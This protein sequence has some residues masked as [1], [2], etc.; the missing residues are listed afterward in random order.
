MNSSEL[1]IREFR[2]RYKAAFRQRNEEWIIRFFGL[3]SGTCHLLPLTAHALT[4]LGTFVLAPLSKPALPAHHNQSSTADKEER[5][6]R[7][8]RS[9]PHEPYREPQ[10]LHYVDRHEFQRRRQE[11]HSAH[12]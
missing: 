12:Y 7:K 1:S 2:P 4:S 9:V 8:Q 10:F 5:N 11:H 3:A 6:F